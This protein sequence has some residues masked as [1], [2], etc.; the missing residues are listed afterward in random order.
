MFIYKSFY[1][2]NEIFFS[3]YHCC[4]NVWN[5]EDSDAFSIKLFDI[6]VLNFL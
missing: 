2:K 4:S 6:V 3:R 5:S 1:E